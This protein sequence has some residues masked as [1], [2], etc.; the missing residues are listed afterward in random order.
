MFETVEMDVFTADSSFGD[1]LEE[2]LAFE[3]RPVVNN[4]DAKDPALAVGLEESPLDDLGLSVGE[5]GV[6][7]A[8][9]LVDGSLNDHVIGDCQFLADEIF[10]TLYEMLL[11]SLLSLI[12]RESRDFLLQP[13]DGVTHCRGHGACR[14]KVSNLM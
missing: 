11:R 10:N 5:D 8:D 12:R 9:V 4:D 7:G 1:A 14:Q 6:T 2:V 13:A 3:E